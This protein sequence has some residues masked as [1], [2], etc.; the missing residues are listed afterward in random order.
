M[1]TLSVALF[2][3]KQKEDY[4]LCIYCIYSVEIEAC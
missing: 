4:V 3:Y 2:F 1:E